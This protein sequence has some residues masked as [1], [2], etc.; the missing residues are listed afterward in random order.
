M[1]TASLHRELLRAVDAGLVTRDTERRP[2][3]YRADRT[4]PLHDAVASLLR[5]TVGVEQQLRDLLLATPGIEAAAIH[6]SWPSGEARPGSDIDLLVVADTVDRRRLRASLRELERTIGRRIDLMLLARHELADLM[7]DDN[8]FLRLVL[9]R[10]LV[11][12]VGDA[13][14]LA[15]A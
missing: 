3:V 14:A 6:G 7:R 10:P 5:M 4:S 13:A 15:R 8:P 1:S 2:H 9:E 11:N 12:L